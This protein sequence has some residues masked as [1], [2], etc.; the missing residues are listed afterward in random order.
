MKISFS[1]EIIKINLANLVVF[2]LILIN[3]YQIYRTNR[4]SKQVI[5]LRENLNLYKLQVKIQEL[6]FKISENKFYRLR[7]FDPKVSS[8][9]DLFLNNAPAVLFFINY[10][11]CLNCLIEEIFEINSLV[12]KYHSFKF[13]G[14][15]ILP[16]SPV[17]SLNFISNLNKFKPNFPIYFYRDSLYLASIN[18]GVSIILFINESGET[19][20]SYIPEP[21]NDLKRKIFYRS[22]SYFLHILKN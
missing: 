3:F 12:N 5:D 19:I 14:I 6:E 13:I 16:K 10:K 21:N 8:E 17:D 22:L 1:K 4:F 15:A 18:L 20:L 7:V 2:F 11:S 9:I